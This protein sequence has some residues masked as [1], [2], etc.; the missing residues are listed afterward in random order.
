MKSR[1]FTALLWLSASM[2]AHAQT[3]SP[4]QEWQYPGGV[5]LQKLFEPDHP[6]WQVI[7]GAATEVEPVY[8]GSSAYRVVAGPVIDIRW[9]DVA[10]ASVGEG[11]GVNLLSGNQYRA[12]VALGYDLGRRVSDD[13]SH[14]EG[15][16]DISAAP[17][18]KAFA[19]YV[20]S[21][22]FPLV[23]RADV[24]RIVGG[25]DGTLGDF[26]LF[27]PLPGASRRLV[28]LA[29]P[30]ITFADKRYTQ[31]LFG[32]TEAQS[33]ASGYPVFDTHA[34]TS[35]EGFGLS[36]THLVTDHWL[37]NLNGA[38]NRLRG[39]ATES[40]ITQKATQRA[41]ALSAAYLW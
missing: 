12:G 13:A 28:V 1:Y 7:L 17:V 22:E 9:R 18:V 40:P 19:S 37:I 35:A 41:L 2:S 34:G 6:E 8:D 15:L 3:P 11:L 16:G 26:E 29:G 5:S 36:A 27:M 20:I 24:R 4:L 21:K 10:F 32:V 23:V 14:L 38:I 33:L 30:S 39:S 31:R 25:S